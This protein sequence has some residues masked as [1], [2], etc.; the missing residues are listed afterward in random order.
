MV[1]YT[2][3]GALLAIELTLLL[4]S[5]GLAKLHAHLIA[6]QEPI[7]HWV[8]AAV[9]GASV[10]LALFFWELPWWFGLVQLAGHLAV[11]DWSLD[12]FRGLSWRYTSPTTGSV[13]DRLLGRYLFY[14]ELLAAVLYVAAQF[15]I[16]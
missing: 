11:F 5:V 1:T 2:P 14:I 9:Y 15:Y 3:F 7:V 10:L 6:E 4:L 8:W 12:A 13:L 16:L